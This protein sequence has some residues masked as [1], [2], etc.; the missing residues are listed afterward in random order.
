MEDGGKDTGCGVALAKARFT[1]EETKVQVG[2]SRS[3]FASLQNL[4]FSFGD[5]ECQVSNPP[6]GQ[7]CRS[8]RGEEAEE[9]SLPQTPGEDAG[10]S[11]VRG[12]DVFY[13]HLIPACHPSSLPCWSSGKDPEREISE[14]KLIVLCPAVNAHGE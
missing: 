12:K 3:G 7:K 1:N 8:M 6:G 13:A 2:N 4:S 9:I 10:L 14:L 5:S 11:Q